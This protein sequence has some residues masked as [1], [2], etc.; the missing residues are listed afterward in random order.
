MDTGPVIGQRAVEL[1]RARS[2]DE[3]LRR[4]ARWSTGC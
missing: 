3:V 1:P 2:P 4:C